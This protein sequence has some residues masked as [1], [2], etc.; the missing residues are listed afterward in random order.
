MLSAYE[1]SADV[2]PAIQRLVWLGNDNHTVVAAGAKLDQLSQAAGIPFLSLPGLVRIPQ[3]LE[4]VKQNRRVEGQTPPDFLSRRLAEAEMACRSA[5]LGARTATANKP[6]A[7]RIASDM[8]AE[9]PGAS[10]GQVKRIG[11]L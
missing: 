10:R 4:A 1:E 5:A 8:Q 6:E 9:W 7:E 11:K 2:L 3:W